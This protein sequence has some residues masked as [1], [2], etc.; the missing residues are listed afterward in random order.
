MSFQLSTL[1]YAYDALEPYIDSM[2]MQIHHDKHHAAYVSNLNAAIEKHAELGSKS[3]DALLSDLSAVPE[4]IRT[5]IRNHGGGT[6]N[7][8]MFWKVMAPK[9]GGEPKGE[10]AKSIESTF[11]SFANFKAEFEKA[12]MG[13]FGSGWAWLVKKGKG[14]AVIST[15]NQDNPMSEGMTPL[16]TLDVWEHAY[17]LKYQNRRAE[18]V[19]NWWNVVNW[20]EVASRYPA[21]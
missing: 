8:D 3:L 12:A 1:P 7:H 20:S 14:L 4:D 2:T 13:R 15:A 17:Y 10:L 18:Y 16:L 21:K 6:W 5:A 9:A 19:S 11:G